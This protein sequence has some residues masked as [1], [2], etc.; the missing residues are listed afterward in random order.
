[1]YLACESLGRDISIWVKILDSE[2][3]LDLEKQV[4]I[5]VSR[6]ARFGRFKILQIMY[7]TR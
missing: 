2:A 6:V 7:V 4:S 1:V 3:T 5:N